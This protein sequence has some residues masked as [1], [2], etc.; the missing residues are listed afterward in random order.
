MKLKEMLYGLSGAGVMILVML[1]V[2]HPDFNA[3]LLIVVSGIFS[4]AAT[5]FG[6]AM[7]DK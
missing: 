3:M 6:V 5:I 4:C 1:L 2:F 7:A